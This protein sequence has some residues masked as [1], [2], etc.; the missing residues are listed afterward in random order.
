[1]RREDDIDQRTART[2]AAF[3]NRPGD[4]FL[5]GNQ[6]PLMWQMFYFLDRPA[7]S[8]LGLDGHPAGANATPEGYR[9]M[10]AGG[11]VHADRG[12]VVGDHAIATTATISDEQRQGRSGSL[13]FVCQRTTIEVD[14]DVALV[15][16]RDIVY[17]PM[18]AVTSASADQPVRRP[19]EHQEP[20][21]TASV[22]VNS[23]LLFRFSALTYN[24][25]RIHYDRDYTREVE[26][27]PG[28]VVHGPLQAL[29]MAE[30][31]TLVQPMIRTFS[32]RLV[33]PL[34]ENDGLNVRAAAG[35]PGSA[36]IESNDERTTATA[37]FIG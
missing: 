33:S 20:T 34:H 25:H 22:K 35:K 27:H 31:A 5:E 3:L 32:Y 15:D 13:R 8:A 37:T 36:W 9:R 7:Q 14:G 28:L 21:R 12:L 16:E 1:M 4:Q 10:F 30:L 26:N 23:T 19:V 24:A 18:P 17:I 11:R 2:V 6:L 29:L